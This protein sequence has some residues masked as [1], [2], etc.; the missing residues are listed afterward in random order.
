MLQEHLAS[1]TFC[2]LASILIA[3]QAVRHPNKLR[4]FILAYSIMTLPASII[5]T[6]YI[7]GLVSARVNSL[8]YLVSTLL[9]TVT[10][11][12]MLL[13]VGKRIR[14]GN[15]YWKHPLVLFGIFFLGC[16]VI[17]LFAQI[18]VLA[19][20]KSE[21]E[22]YPLKPCFIAGVI[23]AIFGDMAIFTYT[24]KPLLYWRENRLNEGHSRTTALGVSTE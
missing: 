11:F 24:F 14:L 2:T 3:Y 8:T 15:S 4:L 18:I 19:V 13:D 21:V 9:M 17:V 6:L 12:F 1:S 22:E 16:T 7:Q 5:S 23:C 20:N 10:H